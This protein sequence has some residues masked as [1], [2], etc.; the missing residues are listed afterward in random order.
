MSLPNPNTTSA[1]L[2][3]FRAFARDPP[4]NPTPIIVIFLS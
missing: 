1:K 2:L 3:F 4:I